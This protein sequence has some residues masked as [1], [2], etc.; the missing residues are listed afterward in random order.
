MK[1][2]QF[3]AIAK[4][5]EAMKHY[6]EV[7]IENFTWRELARVAYDSLEKYRRLTESE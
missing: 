4:M 7:T 5:A 3:D 2:N 1:F 6:D